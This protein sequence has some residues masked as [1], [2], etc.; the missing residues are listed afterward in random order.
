MA[1]GDMQIDDA[2]VEVVEC[3]YARG[4]RDPCLHLGQVRAAA[5]WPGAAGDILDEPSRLGAGARH[6]RG[7]WRGLA[8]RP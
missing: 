3:D 8:Q 6:R 5:A 1:L 2:L 4:V 7:R